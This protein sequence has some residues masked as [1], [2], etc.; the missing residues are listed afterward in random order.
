MQKLILLGVSSLL[1][2]GLFKRAK[3]QFDKAQGWNWRLNNFFFLG[4]SAGRARFQVEM[5]L[6]NAADVA[7]T[8]GKIELRVYSGSTY[9]GI[10]TKPEYFTLPANG[11]NN[12]AFTMEIDLASIRGGVQDVLYSIMNSEDL[13]LSFRGAMIIKQG[14]ALVP[15]PII[16]NTTLKE[17]FA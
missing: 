13:P 17:I 3:A 1:A 7:L 9:L 6:I 8:V 4:Y 5:E 11:S 12:F 16:Y 2:F 10:L 14:V 15:A